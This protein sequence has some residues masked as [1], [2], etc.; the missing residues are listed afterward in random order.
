MEIK[1]SI[2]NIIENIIANLILALLG[3]A[4]IVLVWFQQLEL[5]QKLLLVLGAIALVLFVIN[6]YSLWKER[7]KKGLSKLSDKEI[8]DT[9]RKWLFDPMF[10]LQP[11]INS[12]CFFEFEIEDREGKFVTISRTKEN[13]TNILLSS[14]IILNEDQRNK[15]SKLT[16]DAQKNFAH[17]LRIEM[18]RYGIGYSGIDTELKRIS[19]EN[20]ILLDDSLNEFQLLF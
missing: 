10:K 6:Q 7:H 12:K 16:L 3:V 19:L 20:I 2:R 13:P 4:V 11:M 14:S 9:I 18:A 1:K 8:E 17:L 15:H 5:Y